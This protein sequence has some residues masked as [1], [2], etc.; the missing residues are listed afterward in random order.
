[1]SFIELNFEILEK[2]KQAILQ[3]SIKDKLNLEYININNP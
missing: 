3:E 2:E 1:M